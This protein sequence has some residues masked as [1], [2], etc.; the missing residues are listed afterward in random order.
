MRQVHRL[1]YLK[2]YTIQS[3]LGAWAF[4][5]YEPNCRNSLLFIFV[6]SK[7]VMHAKS[8]WNVNDR[9]R[10]STTRWRC[11]EN[12]WVVSNFLREGSEFELRSQ[13]HSL[14]AEALSAHE[15]IQFYI[16]AQQW[17]DLYLKVAGYKEECMLVVHGGGSVVWCWRTSV[18]IPYPPYGWLDLHL[19][20]GSAC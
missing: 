5:V 6:F 3:M 19:L 7:F 11:K 20:G 12:L 8:H 2:L 9:H 4:L 17:K 16:L 10:W 14:G 1:S 13:F 15:P 18:R